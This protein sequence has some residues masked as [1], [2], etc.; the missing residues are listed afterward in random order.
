M[1]FPFEST[2]TDV[3]IKVLFPHDGQNFLSIS[4]VDLPK[5]VNKRLCVCWYY[6]HVLVASVA[7]ENPT[8]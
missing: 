7:T 4:F 6:L 3:R 5:K 8:L 2:P 1:T